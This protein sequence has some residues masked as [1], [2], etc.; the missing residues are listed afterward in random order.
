MNGMT[1]EQFLEWRKAR[2]WRPTERKQKAC[3]K[4]QR[5][6]VDFATGNATHCVDCIAE[7]N[8]QNRANWYTK[9]RKVKR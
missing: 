3:R 1:S 8:R 7:R 2:G 5:T 6:D 4:C 9:N